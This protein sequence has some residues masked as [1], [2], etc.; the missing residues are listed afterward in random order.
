MKN[1]IA[2]P[3]DEA[4]DAQELRLGQPRERGGAEPLVADHRQTADRVGDRYPGEKDEQEDAEQGR[5]R[6]VRYLPA[7]RRRVLPFTTS[8]RQRAAWIADSAKVI[9]MTSCTQPS[10]NGRFESAETIPEAK[11]SRTIE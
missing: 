4:V 8:H 5:E 2:V 3:R 11:L 1:G 6:H 10:W 7:S 9:G